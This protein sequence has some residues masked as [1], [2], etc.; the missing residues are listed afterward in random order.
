MNKFTTILL[1]FI[2]SNSYCQFAIL[3]D[4]IK[5]PGIYKTFEEF[6]DN[7]P[8]LKTDF[9]GSGFKIVE[10]EYQ[11]AETFNKEKLKV[12]GFDMPF[13]MAQNIGF[14]FGFCDGKSS[15]ISV[16]TQQYP[17]YHSFYKVTNF[18]KICYYDVYSSSLLSS[19]NTSI[20]NIGLP[21]KM[22]R[23]VFTQTVNLETGE[24]KKLS[25]KLIKNLLINHP[26][27]QQKFELEEDKK[28]FLKEYL[29]EY[30]KL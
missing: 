18:G 11:N 29:E 15:Y 19:G 6:R 4:S 24:Y 30:N 25:I 9:N 17:N 12:Y 20:K 8:S 27:L 16:E 2:F 22:N 3:T 28:F 1:L 10:E 14:I 5:K 21:Y 26:V 13:K 7:N 23:K